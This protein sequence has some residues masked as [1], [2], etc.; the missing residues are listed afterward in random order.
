MANPTV[1]ESIVTANQRV[2]AAVRQSDAAAIAR[3]YTSDGQI[4]PPQSEPVSGRSA[5][6]TFWQAAL[7]MGISALAL[8]TVEVSDLGDTA[9]EVGRFSLAAANGQSVDHGKYVVI[10]HKEGGEWRLYRDIWN[11]SVAPPG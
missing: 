11:T 10:W 7:G 3:C 6:E 1:R 8:E 4:L 5:I 2:M 9:Y